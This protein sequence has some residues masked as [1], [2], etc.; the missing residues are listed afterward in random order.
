MLGNSEATL[1]AALTGTAASKRVYAA[2]PT[3]LTL[4]ALRV[5]L[6]DS[7]PVFSPW[8]LTGHLLQVDATA[9]TKAEAWALV[10]EV[11]SRLEA[12]PGSAPA[13]ATVSEVELQGVTYNP[14]ERQ[15]PAVPSYAL[16][17]KVYLRS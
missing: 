11:V 14:D 16:T 1:I 17:V 4:P 2:Y 13:G 12:L 3:N 5:S 10:E 9:K 6:L 8:V 7:T 15:D